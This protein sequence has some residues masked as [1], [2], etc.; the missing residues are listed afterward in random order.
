MNEYSS[1][2]IAVFFAAISP[3]RAAYKRARLQYLAVR[4]G[5][6]LLLLSARI[7]L[8]VGT[9]EP[10]KERF[11]AGTIEAGQW[12][13]PQDELTVEQ[14][15]DALLSREGLAVDG[16]GHLMLASTQED[17]ISASAPML[18]HP[19]GLDEGNRLAVL[20]VS[21]S[22]RYNY[23]HQPDTDWMLKAGK[24]P[25]DTV[26]ELTV[27]YGLGA[28]RGDKALL[29]V[30]ALN[31]IQVS[32]RSSVSG[33]SANIG[34][35]MGNGLD[36]AKAQVGYRV[37]DKGNVVVRGAVSGHDLEWDEEGNAS[38]GTTTIEIP[39]GGV[40]QC[41]ASYDGHAHHLRWFA[42]PSV[43]QNP[44]LAVLS[45]VD[46]AGQLLRG[47]LLPD[48]PPRGKAA[49]D[50]ETAVGWVIWGLG[51]APA[52]FGTNSKTRDTFDTVAVSPNG[53]FLVAECTLG[54]LKADSKLSKLGARVAS[55]REMLDAANMR[56]LQILPVII[57]AMTRD[58]VKADLQQ[59]AEMGVLVLTRE[60]LE[61]AF[62]ELLRFPDADNLFARGLQSL[63]ESMSAGT[64]EQLGMFT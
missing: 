5:S 37:I 20:S 59:A 39:L 47:Y 48:L 28:L 45:A 36:K 49:D 4:D 56:H 33:T 10:P 24:V 29:E 16:H 34:V 8:G 3:W 15:L 26:N 19:E 31:A 2:Q 50:F 46:Q 63:R 57:T 14:A 42:D 27:E 21:G 61:E 51:F 62:N 18:L 55:L 22:Q 35:W 64:P 17:D 40:I 13:I 1:Q 30:I 12:D 38:V 43:F 54:L 11:Q 58:Q 7:Y 23:L 41:I 52:S 25:F 6:H 9:E 53:N 32:A 44:R 60:N